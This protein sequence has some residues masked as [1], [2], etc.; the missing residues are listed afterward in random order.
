MDPRIGNAE[1]ETA[2]GL[3]GEHY[4]A[5]RLDH[6]EYD[7]RLD[8][9]WSA[10]TAADLEQLFWDLPRPV[11][12]SPA[13]TT[14]TPRRRGPGV[15]PLLLVAVVVAFAVVLE[16][17]WLVLVGAAWLFLARPGRARAH[18]WHGGRGHGCR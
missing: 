11:S 16:A 1:R 10:R 13:R 18:A 4:A 12:A 7:E 15:S 3:L 6:E 14:R 2:T 9:I 5:G 8:A 17:P